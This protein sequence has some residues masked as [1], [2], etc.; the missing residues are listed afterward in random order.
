MTK[1]G[2]GR[3]HLLAPQSYTGGTTVTEGILEGNTQ[4]LQGNILNNWVVFF[5]QAADGT[6]AANISGS[7]ALVKLGTGVVQL[8]GNNTYS[9]LTRIEVGSLRL[10]GNN[11]IGDLT[12]VTL[13]NTT[14]VLLDLAG[15]NESIG[16]LAGGGAA[17]GNV[18][19][20]TGTLTTGGNNTDTTF[21]GV[22]S[23]T[24]AVTKTGSGTWTLTGNNTY[25][26]GTTFA[27]GVA[28]ASGD[29]NLG[30]IAAPLRFDGGTLRVTGAYNTTP[31][32]VELLAGGGGLDIAN[33]ANSFT[34]T[35]NISGPGG[36]TKAGT[37]TLTLAGA[38]IYGGPTTI[39]AGTLR[40]EL[41]R[42]IPDSSAVTLANTAGVLLDIDAAETIGS[43]AGGGPAGGNVSVEA[44]TLTTGG[45][46]SSTT[47]A[48]SITGSGSLVK[49]GSGVF[50]LAGNN[51]Y[52]GITNVEQGTLRLGAA[53]GVPQNAN[54][55]VAL[56]A[57]LDL[58]SFDKTLAR[59]TGNGSVTL[60]A[61]DLTLNV[62]GGTG[63]TF[64]G[65][66]TGTGSLTKTGDGT[67]ELNGANSYTGGT[68]VLAGRLRGPA[69]GLQGNIVNQAIV[70]FSQPSDGTYGGTLSGPGQ[71]VKTGAG[72]VTISS[73][74]TYT[75][76]TTVSQ[77]TLHVPNTLNT[78]GGA[79]QIQSSGVLEASGI[80]QRA[81]SGAAHSR[82]PAIS[83]PAT[84][85]APAAFKPALSMSAATPLFYSMPTAPT[86]AAEPSLA[87]LLHPSPD[88]N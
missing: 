42:A 37:G 14:G 35:G 20:G 82:P 36:L 77:G 18:A 83:L 25:S 49:R 73:P 9:G 74:A 50:T 70:D 31:R 81:I 3:L 24:G 66:I 6:T 80:I 1:I 33:A 79:T 57:T 60:G 41:Q 10:A 19:L 8:T 55:I 48:G 40:A 2:P 67:L 53:T 45:D 21:A 13:Y 87:V 84:S 16:S 75:G 85:P 23:G 12:A 68:T 72:K 4:S 52:F 32:S 63:N 58:N 7:G 39:N 38:N 44:A 11:A 65:N 69:S 5:N 59:L 29:V 46:N 22:I 88:W 54:V 51:T 62:F 17:G 76:T 61:G 71:L 34:Y 64:A 47:F 26:G 27:G 78:P 28:S 30:D 43:L 86:S 15:S 56:G